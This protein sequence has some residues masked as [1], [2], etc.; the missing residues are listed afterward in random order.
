M[1]KINTQAVLRRV[2]SWM[3]SF[4]PKEILYTK[5][6]VMQSIGG[7]AV[8]GVLAFIGYN[9]FFPASYDL[10]K[11]RELLPSVSSRVAK[12]LTYE[13]EK[14]QFV[15]DYGSSDKESSGLSSGTV[16]VIAPRNAS[17][18]VVVQDGV[19]NV[20]FVLKPKF[21]VESGKAQ[22]GRVI[23]PL[24]SRD[25]WLVYTMQSGG[26]KED[27]L[28]P[29]PSGD[30]K[31]YKY[32]MDLGDSYE[33]RLEDDGSVGVYGDTL[34]SGDVQTGTADD[35]ALL[36]KAR[37]RAEKTT[38]LFRIPKP[39]I[40]EYDGPGTQ[41]EAKYE[42]DGNMLTVKVDNLLSADYPVSIDPTIYVASA[43]QFM[44]G[45][46][47]TNVDFDVAN[48]LI[49]KGSTTGAR[50]DSWDPTTALPTAVWNASTA[51][52]GGFIYSVG[53]ISFNGQIY[54][55]QGSSSFT[56]PSGVTSITVEMWGGG[57]GGGGGAAS[58]AG[59]AG[60][61]G[62]YVTSTHTTT[63]GESL[64]VYVGGGGSGGN[65]DSGGNDAGGGGGGGGYSRL[66]RS[67]TT[68][69]LAAGG[70]GGGGGRNA[71]A[72]AAGGAAGGTTGVAGT[73][74]ATDNGRGG[75][76]G[77]PSAGGTSG[78]S[79]GNDGVSGSS[80]TGGAGGDGRTNDGADGSGAAGGLATGGAGGSPNVNTTRGGG[81]GGG[82]GYFGGAGGGATSNTNGAAGGGGGGGSSYTIAGA[83]SVTNTSGS[84]TSPGNSGD[85][86]RGGAADGGGGGSSTN[87]GTAG[88]NGI[89]IITYSG[90]GAATSAAVNWAKFNTTSGTIDSTNP[91]GGACSG[92]CTT[93]AYNLPSPR[94]NFSLVAYNGFL[95]AIGG[96]D[97]SCTSG[98]GTGDGGVCDTVYVAKLG[99][100]GEP[101][102]WHPSDSVKDN[103]GY[104]YRDADLTSPRSR[105]KVSA[106]NNRL[107][108]MGGVTSASGVKSV[109][110]STQISEMTANGVLNTWSTSTNLPYNAYGYASQIYNDRVYLIGGA[111]SIGGS[112]LATVYYSKISST[113]GTLGTWQQTTSLPAARMTDGGEMS[114]AWGAYM[115]VSGGCSAVNG[116]GYCTTI[117]S[118]TYVSSINADGT[119]DDWNTVGSL[120]DTRTGHNIMAWRGYIY[121]IGGC[122]AQNTSTGVCTTTLSTINYGDVNQDGDAS[123]VDQSVPAG[124]AP[125]NGGSPTTCDLPGTTYIGNI[126]NASIVANGYLYVIGGCTS[127]TCG[128]TSAN[129]AYTA[130][131]SSGK[132]SAPTCSAP[133]NLRGNIW[134]VDTTNTI[135][136]GIGASSPVL[137]GGRLYLVGGLTGGGNTNAIVR[138]TLNSDGTIGAWTSQSM[139]G[140]G[141]TSVSYTYSFARAD[142]AN[143]GSNPGNLYVFGGC[144]T[145]TNMGCSAYAQGVYK[146]NI[147]TTG[148]LTGCSNSGQLQIGTVS[149][150]SGTG[151]AAMSGTVYANYVYLIGGLAPSLT[152]LTTVRYARINNSNDIVTTGTGWVQDDTEMV[153]GRRRSSAFGYNGY[154]YAVGGYDAG[155]GVLADI[156]FVKIN[157]SDGSLG[158]T[159]DGFHVSE[160]EIN[161]RWGLTVPISNSFA[162][163]IGGCTDGA[164]PTCNGGGPTDTIETF[165]IYNNDSG[166]PASY[167]T[168]ANTY[169]TNPN[170][171]GASAAILN[172][173]LYVAGGCT[174][175]GDCTTAVNTV[176]YTT[177]DSYGALSSWSNT[178]GVF[179]SGAL[180]TWGKLAAAGTSLYY[181]GGQDST[182]SNEQSTVYY[183]TPAGGGDVSTWTS[184]TALPAA[185]T[186]FGVAVWNNRIYVV[187]GLDGSAADTNTV[188]V[189][190]QQNSGGAISSWSTSSTS[191]DT[192][193]SGA[194]AVAYANNLYVLGGYDGANYLSDVQ[195][196]KLDSTTGDAGSWTDTNSMPVALS[197]ADAFASNGYLYM[198]GGR[199]AD[200]T[201]SPRTL[202]APISANT[203]IG[204][205]N[206][207]TGIG[208]WYETNQRF[209]GNRY[210]A[211]AAYYDGKAYVMGGGCGT[212]LT[213][214]SPVTQ[215]TTLLSQ[216]QVAKYSRRID[217][218]T[219]VFPTRWLLNGVDNSIG[220]RWQT[221]YRSAYDSYYL[222][223]H[224]TFDQGTNGSGVTETTTAYDNCYAAGSG[225]NVYS[226]AQYVTPGLSMYNSV[227]GGTN[228]SAACND[229]FAATSIR[230]DRF[231]V[232]FASNPG[233]N[234]T[235]FSL[236]N[237]SGVDEVIGALR[238][239]TTGALQVRD[240]IVAEGSTL[241][242]GSGAWHRVEVY[243]NRTG[244][245]MTTRVYSGANLHSTTASASSTITLNN[246][247]NTD[248]DQ[249]NIGMVSGLTTAWGV[250]IDDHKASLN[251]W[252]GSA[253]PPW[254][255]STAF[256]DT[257]LGTLN[258]FTPK[259]VSGSNTSYAR[260]Y[261]F[262]TSI[263]ASKTYGYPDDVSRGPTIDDL[264]LY[265]TAD[266]SKRLMHGRT[267][268]GGEQQP[269]D[270]PKY[271][272]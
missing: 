121:E 101:Q 11:S 6:T 207:P 242:L 222:I 29:K 87:N 187:G 7:L 68:L 266:P 244:T 134:C 211:A 52:A 74:I 168:A 194:A 179:P 190:S 177:I 158:S 137:F 83:T 59:G 111:S 144:S 237:I 164:S 81:G 24:S 188:Y 226:N 114:S 42:L 110:N 160:V 231:Y 2:Q 251:N 200:T 103:W 28:L 44:A 240:G 61:G 80:L 31:E 151:L 56:V 208:E 130:I 38:L 125:C 173:K 63:P 146:C 3:Q 245:T 19:N 270:T 195:F 174:S 49:K 261:N 159:G 206:N 115:Y 71:T 259:D 205:G 192:A 106:Y 202:V 72:G 180:R 22:D 185:R 69:S 199:S 228:G 26:V 93:S 176:S 157:V 235:I 170:R 246:S 256:G 219:N 53:G 77:T 30:S 95:Y 133:N 40:R 113:D 213:Y 163:A 65:Y 218:D 252:P 118:N 4:V 46:N 23:Y 108:L 196:S 8:V 122:S 216:P 36:K 33:A 116:S 91:G 58:A 131:S 135:S 224:A 154:L 20:D 48:S 1:A 149:G 35:A 143:A 112:P 161:N 43:E 132:M 139:T 99:A 230:Y 67:G 217:T 209:S 204:S 162:Y 64:T 248:F 238:V 14:Q 13:G 10:G 142:P 241:A 148:A 126:L 239:T 138:T 182:A 55:T 155:A 89:M 120:S 15:F 258:T 124:T 41:V 109:V 37:D 156:E 153:V 147:Q 88:D 263:D 76:A 183:G 12:S 215:Q 220:A 21:S 171:I 97:S 214:A 47:E 51:A 85:A 262:E 92:W 269:L 172:G 203:T 84:G 117:A 212:T 86:D 60:G 193:R 221:N 62:G 45:N 96:E 250:Y 107:Y 17:K 94:S 27:I 198:I 267:F 57:G 169:G 254:G 243:M 32:E 127:N 90:G 197:Q 123:T 181:I 232:Y 145:S 152:D 229:D 225:S 100:N 75:P 253:F 141:M 167:A 255:Q 54:T 39:E 184:T 268:T 271:D 50:F 5:P 223:H 186:K 227:P 105:M 165:Q 66:L 236:T 175:A 129:V 189:S 102:L 233:S 257:T 166:A 73:S 136:G 249:A 191:F 78:T 34:L 264:S 79:Q 16:K 18:G 98:N 265:F 9:V 272:Y 178:T 201:C 234:T 25:G 247:T 128:S 119:I 260:W 104:W 150:A 82:A 210:G 140:L 70:G